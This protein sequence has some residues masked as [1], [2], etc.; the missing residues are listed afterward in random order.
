MFLNSRWTSSLQKK[1]DGDQWNL[2]VVYKI[3]HKLN[4]LKKLSFDNDEQH[5]NVSCGHGSGGP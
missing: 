2:N 3:E 5:N 4:L 1:I